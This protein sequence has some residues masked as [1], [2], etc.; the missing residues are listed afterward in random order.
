MVGVLL[1]KIS[2]FYS[3]I[4]A[5]KWQVAGGF[6]Q[7]FIKLYQNGGKMYDICKNEQSGV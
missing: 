1:S 5:G 3:N 4:L 6:W 2:L 7:W